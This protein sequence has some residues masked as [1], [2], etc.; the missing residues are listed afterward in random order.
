MA[1]KIVGA[2]KLYKLKRQ[3][4]PRPDNRLV[5][6]FPLPVLPLCAR[7]RYASL[8]VQ[9]AAYAGCSVQWALW[10]GCTEYSE[11]YTVQRVLCSPG[12]CSPCACAP[13]WLCS[14]VPVL[15]CGPSP[16]RR[17]PSPP[18]PSTLHYTT[19]PV[20]T[21]QRQSVLHRQCTIYHQSVHYSA[22]RPLAGAP[23]TTQGRSRPWGRRWA[24][25]PTASAGLAKSRGINGFLANFEPF[26]R[27][28]PVVWVL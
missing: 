17:S 16:R 5:S 22:S 2:E 24:D 11:V 9:R 28:S 27:L 18:V 20:C 7:A 6:Q 13:L 23:S 8:T 19:W 14:S 15:P 26:V 10:E 4:Q 21:L 3:T 1:C 25:R 12:L